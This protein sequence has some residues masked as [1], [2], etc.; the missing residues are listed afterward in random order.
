LKSNN[1]R[2]RV[3]AP[4][5]LLDR[6]WGK[7]PQSIENEITL[8]AVVDH[9]EAIEGFLARIGALPG[10]VTDAEVV[11]ETVGAAEP[12]HNGIQSHSDGAAPAGQ[13]P[14]ASTGPE[15]AK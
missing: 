5:V 2:A 15:P 3:A 11:D 7:P 8:H 1:E 4:A 9:S 6:G 13:A 12:S 14:E 10:P